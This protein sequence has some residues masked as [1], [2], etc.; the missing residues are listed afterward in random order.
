MIDYHLHTGY[1]WDAKG[2]VEDFCEVAIEKKMEEIAFTNHFQIINIDKPR[3]SITP[4]Q[5]FKHAKDIQIAKEK[6]DL[7]IKLGLECDYWQ[8]YHRDIERVLDEHDFDFILGSV[9]YVEGYLI[10]AGLKIAAKFF[11]GKSMYEVYEAYFKNVIETVESQLFDVIAHPDSIRKNTV[12][13]YGKELPFERYKILVE[14]LIEALVDNKVG[15][16]INTS[17]YIHGIND[18][19]PS[20][21]FLKLCK[22]FGIKTVV[23]GSDAHSP[24]KIGFKLKEGIEKLRSTGYEKI[25]LFDLRKAKQISIEEIL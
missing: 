17:G 11:E 3:G 13:F 12:R 19:F 6:F 20:L 10:G 9:H 16:E 15:I 18:C 1:T 7:K 24:I 5:L 25:S 8:A 22:G 4:E 21:D 14:K 23:I 2:K